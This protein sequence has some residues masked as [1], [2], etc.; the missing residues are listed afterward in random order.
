VHDRYQ[1]PISIKWPVFLTA[2][3]GQAGTQNDK[4]KLSRLGDTFRR[5]F[6]GNSELPARPPTLEEARA[7]VGGDSSP[8]T[9]GFVGL[10]SGL[11]VAY[12]GKTGYPAGFDPRDRPWYQLGEGA[13]G[14]RWGNPYIDSISGRLLLPSAMPLYTDRGTFLGVA[15][16]DSSFDYII[17]VLMDQPDVDGLRR[18]LLLDNIGRVVVDSAHR[19]SQH[20]AGELH[21]ALQL[22]PFDEPSVVERVRAGASGAL[23]L[24]YQ[25]QNSVIAFYPLTSLDWTYVAI[26]DRAVVDP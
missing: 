11:M 14:I 20:Q 7:S 15:G 4:M 22:E 10:E 12:P 9:W 26:A 3:D 21:A 23:E 19:R 6:T 2:A 16:L 17:D 24:D 18:T 5:I 1:R 8:I 13:R 25:G